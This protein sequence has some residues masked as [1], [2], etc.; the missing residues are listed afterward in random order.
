MAY[1]FKDFTPQ[2]PDDAASSSRSFVIHQPD[3]NSDNTPVKREPIRRERLFSVLAWLLVLAIAI[4]IFW[5]V[6]RATPYIQYEDIADFTGVTC[7]LTD[8]FGQAIYQEGKNVNYTIFGNLVGHRDYIHNSLLYRHSEV[9]CPDGINPVFGYRALEKE[10]RVMKTTLLSAE[11]Q[12]TIADMFAGAEGCCFAY[13]YETGEVYTALSFPSF[14]PAAQEPSYINRCFSS[15]YIPGSTMKIVTAALAVDQSKD[16]ENITY[17]CKGAYELSDGNTVNCVGAHGK[18][19]FSTAIGKSC[20]C[21]FA[22]LIQSLDLEKALTSLRE[23]GFA[24]NENEKQN[25][26][27]DGLNKAV[28][29]VNITNTASFKNIWGLIGQGHTQANPID[30]ARLAAA[31]VNGGRAAQPYV[32]SSVTAH[33][34]REKTVQ[35]AE[36]EMIKLLSKDTAEAT[37]AFWKDGVN[38]YYYTRQGMSHKIDYAKTGTAEQG[39]RTED[40][41]LVGVI[42]S[43][44][45]AFYI[46]VEGGQGPTP[47]QIANTLVE[48]L[49]TNG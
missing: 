4:G 10:P 25:E 39:D 18:I 17:T 16:V 42:E 12:Q 7:M 48:L 24:V 26:V 46:V 6:T 36:T 5:G 41:L 49:P 40:K 30:M 15:V 20:N 14:D 27:V 34:R 32:V 21:Y 35:K 38:A 45:T 37:A 9:L 31:V 8:R 47:M 22:Q 23:M 11:S 44:K 3:N 19:G 29:S 43:A 28:S 2:Q 13:N 1:S 33:G